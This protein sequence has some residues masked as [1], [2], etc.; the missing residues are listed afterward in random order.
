MTTW[1][2]LHI[3]R[4]PYGHSED[5]V[6]LVRLEAADLIEKMENKMGIKSIVDIGDI[7]LP[8]TAFT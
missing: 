7:I 3:L 8:V 2:I 1:D 5:E 4:S 6:R